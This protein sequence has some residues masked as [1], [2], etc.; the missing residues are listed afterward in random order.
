[1]TPGQYYNYIR[2]LAGN[3][4]LVGHTDEES[5]YFRGELE[6]FY[7]DLRNRVRFPAVIAESFELDYNTEGKKTRETSFIV[8]TNYK[9][10]KNWQNIYAAMNLCERIGDEFLRRMAYDGDLDVIC[11]KVEPVSAVPVLNEQHLY[12]GIRYTIR[13]VSP[14][15]PDPD[16]EQWTDTLAE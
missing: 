2:E 14:F 13:V 10:A 15:D 6:E 5:H 3:H 16:P 9:E 11:A 1:M 12:A 7:T 8:A 4:V